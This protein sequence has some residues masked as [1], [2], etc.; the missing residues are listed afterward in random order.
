MAD[1]VPPK[2]T[3]FAITIDGTD[4]VGTIGTTASDSKY[5]FKYPSHDINGN[6][7][8]YAML[9]W[10]QGDRKWYICRLNRS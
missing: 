8:K 9:D 5:P 6:E 3:A 7:I 1:P 4:Y 2:F 10:H